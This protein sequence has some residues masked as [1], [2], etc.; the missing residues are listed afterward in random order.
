MVERKGPRVDAPEQA[1]A[2]F[3]RGLAGVEHTLEEREDKKAKVLFAIIRE[4]GR[5]LIEPLAE[6]V[7]Q[8]IQRLPWPKSMRWGS[9]RLPL[10]ATAAV[11]TMPVRWQGRAVPG[12]GIS[13]GDATR[14]HRFLAPAPFTVRDF[15][16]YVVK[17]REAKVIL[18][19]AER[20]AMIAQ[21]AEEMARGEGHVLADD[22]GL[23]DEI[24]GLVE[25]PVPLMGSIDEEFMALPAEAL[26]GT[27]RANQKYLTM[28]TTEGAL[29]PRFVVVANMAASD[30]GTAIVAGNERVL[31]ARLW[32]ARFF[33]DQDRKATLESRLPAMERMVFHAELGTQ[34]QRV[35]RLVALAGALVPY[36]P[37]ADRAMSERA[38]LLAKA[39]LLT[40][41]VGEFPELQGIMGGHYARVQG[42]PAA[43]AAAI[44]DHYAPKGPDDTCPSAPDSVVV[45]LADKLDTLTGFFAADIRPTGSKDPF[46]LRR[47]GLGI[48]RLILENRLRLRLRQAFAAALAGYGERFRMWQPKVWPGVDGVSR[49]PPQGPPARSRCAPR[50]RGGCICGRR[51]GRSC[52]ADRAGRSAAGVSR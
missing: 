9:A 52:P 18:D 36:V 22:P 1:R 23:L 13:S 10:G 15:A 4:H 3:L 28:R 47:A 5:P 35:E 42:E 31:R 8:A 30:G 50:R 20:R 43:V 27:M 24:K 2:G 7:P 12:A 51:R 46:A 44:R 37:S 17:L 32:D 19:G 38:A 29:A 11:D 48:I 34:G 45:A 41:M 40:G 33:W 16:E 49:R 39:D 14:G 25:W 26:V 21:A 6:L